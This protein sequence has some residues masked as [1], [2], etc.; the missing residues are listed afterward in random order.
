[1]PQFSSV[2]KFLFYNSI[3]KGFIVILK[4]ALKLA[5][6]VY[7]NQLD[8]YVQRVNINDA[9]IERKQQQQSP[10]QKKEELR[11]IFF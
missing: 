7:G 10:F 2:Q 5:P 1:M 3:Q 6:C 8:T 4:N 9:C 11:F